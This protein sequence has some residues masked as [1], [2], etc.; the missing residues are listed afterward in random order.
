MPPEERL[1]PRFAAEPPQDLLPYGRWGER[2]QAEFLAACL[3]VDTGGEELGDPGEIA[4]YPD[5]T[6]HG[7]TFVPATTR[8][9]NGYELFG[10]VSFLP[11]SGEDEPS[12]FHA[13]ADF[14][15]DVAEANPDWTIDL[16]DEVIGSWRG[17]EGNVAAMTLLWG[18]PLRAQSA[19]VV[20]AELARLT[21]DQCALV[22]GRFTLLAPDDYRG[23][24]LEVAVYDERGNQLARESLYD[25]EDEE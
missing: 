17:E 20:T 22:E 23:D 25:D 5:R 2:L 8:T 3:A 4:W 10:Y 9:A 11:A 24:T 19:A 15:A 21:V 16:C 7:R 14:T 12:D 18:R 1:V 6:W 13:S